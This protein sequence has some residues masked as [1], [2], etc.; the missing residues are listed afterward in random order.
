FVVDLATFG[1]GAAVIDYDNDGWEDL[2]ITGGALSDAL[3]K[4]NGD[5][6][7]KNVF[8]Q[9]G[10]ASTQLAFTQGAT[11]ADINKDGYKDLIITTM[12]YL[13]FERPSAPN[14]LFLNNGDGSFTDVTEEWGLAN[15]VSNSTGATF[16]DINADGYP[17]LYV[18][19]YFST[20]LSNVSIYNEAT[21]TN[22]LNP[23]TDYLFLNTGGNGFVEVSE[24][25]GMNHDGF[26]FQGLF[27]DFDNDDDLDLYIANDFGFR[28]TPNLFYRNDFPNKRMKDRALNMAINYG[29]NAM[30]IAAADIDYDGWMDYFVTN[31]STS[32][33]TRN[34]G[35]GKGFEDYTIPSGV[36]L[37]TIIDSVYTGPPI[38]WGA[39]FF[40]YDHDMDPDLF[41]CNGALNPTIRVNPNLFFEN[42]EGKFRES[43]RAKNLFDLR[44]GRGSVVFDY[45]K[46]GDLDLFVVNQAPVQP[47]NL[48]GTLPVARC[49]LYRNDAADGNWLQIKL[50]G[51]QADRDGLGAR[52][53]L[54]V[55]GRMLIR[56]IAGGS[57]HLSQNTTI[58]HFGLGEAANVESISVR[59]VGGKTQ[60]IE[61][62]SVNQRIV[63]EEA[64]E[65]A[66]TM[67]SPQL[68]VS[69]AAFT[70][71]VVLEFELADRATYTLD[72]FDAQGRLIRTLD[73]SNVPALTG[74]M[75]W[76][77]EQSLAR[78]VYFFSLRTDEEV[79]T[80]KAIRF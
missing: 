13:E 80:T 49:L 64:E 53:E 46:D 34:K 41:V 78:G 57:S 36:I 20:A 55:D 58:A 16:G 70:N 6:T 19:N 66:G 25:Y 56:E 51:R 33:L 31:L 24:V 44:I 4:N 1:G 73:Q 45:D 23:G 15:Y 77:P 48:G 40:D 8:S 12:H 61:N 37:P 43:A 69:P 79:V 17:D 9:S 7:F 5:G 67:R 30:G 50:E 42:V 39:N 18:S 32:L 10:F 60:T 28:K 22:S 74:A 71:R 65:P 62:V 14:L 11:A 38:S 2:Y 59:W 29:M 76:E 72:V 54:M 68:K 35:E 47:T 52:I 75:V 63:I 3:Y 26:G 21:I 27:T